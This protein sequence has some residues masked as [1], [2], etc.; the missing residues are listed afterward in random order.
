MAFSRSCMLGLFSVLTL[1]SCN[2]SA[3][4]ERARGV[5]HIENQPAESPKSAYEF[6]NSIGVNTHLSYFDRLYGNF[7]LVSKEL[8]SLGIRHLRDGAHIGNDAYNQKLYGRWQQLASYGIRFNVVIDPR[9]KHGQLTPE[10]M[11]LIDDTSGHTIES[12]EGPNELDVSRLQD[13]SGVNRGYQ[14]DLFQ[15]THALRAQQKIAVIGPSMA[16]ASNGSALGDISQIADFGNLHPYPAGKMPSA[17]LDEQ[18]RF[19]RQIFGQRPIVFTETGYHNAM[20]D[21]RAQPAVSEAAAAKYIPR[22]YLEDFLHG[23]YRTYLYE[24]LDEADE[25]EMKEMERHWGLIR[26]DGTEKPAFLSL[27]N[28]IAEV[29]DE[30]P[31][32]VLR[33]L[34][35]SLDTQVSS[36]HHLL[37]QCSNGD[38][39]LILWNE[40]PSYDLK[41]Q[42][43]IVNPPSKLSVSF[44]QRISKIT[45]YDPCLQGG[46]LKMIPNPNKVE[47]E[48]LDRPLILRISTH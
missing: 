12:F 10:V 20:N 15:S 7:D 9:D 33:P 5:D 48:V 27:K 32:I 30:R 40:V 23:I 18:L 4:Q 17:V 47:L 25:P 29:R 43:E 36:I 37:L 22:L 45:E 42:K 13:W 28:L 6:F 1:L 19:A 41:L 8:K 3:E 38:Y 39:L 26:Y 16:H 11:K 24:F 31:A 34:S 44:H 35:F 2:M 14:K 46:P 21:H